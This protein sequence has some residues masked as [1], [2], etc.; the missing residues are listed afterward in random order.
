MLAVSILKFREV[1][2]SSVIGVSQ[3]KPKCIVGSLRRTVPVREK[4]L[5]LPAPAAKKKQVE[6]SYFI[7]SEKKIFYQISIIMVTINL[8]IYA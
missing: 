8:Q 3:I 5:L 7:I 6:Y 4:R 1:I 2:S